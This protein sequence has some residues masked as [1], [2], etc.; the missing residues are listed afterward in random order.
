MPRLTKRLIKQWLKAVVGSFFLWQIRSLFFIF[1]TSGHWM[2]QIRL[3]RENRPVMPGGIR[4]F[5]PVRSPA[6]PEMIIRDRHEQCFFK[7][8]TRPEIT[9]PAAPVPGT[10]GIWLKMMGL[11]VHDQAGCS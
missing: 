11:P 2:H 4:V 9:I 3:L 7:S 5:L 6:L 8:T 10:T 1:C